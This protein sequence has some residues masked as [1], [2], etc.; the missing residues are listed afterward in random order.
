MKD[1]HFWNSAHCFDAIPEDLKKGYL[2]GNCMVIFKGDAN[3]RRL[4]LAKMWDPTKA[5]SQVIGSYFD[6]NLV[7]L[8]TMKSDCAVGIDKDVVNKMEAEDPHWRHNG[9]RGVIQC[10][11]K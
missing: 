6:G 8:R 9:K 4:V 2:N 3:Y 7:T 1:D 10:H 11:L 5:F